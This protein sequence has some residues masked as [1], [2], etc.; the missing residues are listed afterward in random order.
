M[1]KVLKLVST[2]FPPRFIWMPSHTHGE[3]SVH[4]NTKMGST[5]LYRDEKGESDLLFG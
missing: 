2:N 4:E 5:L 1:S 3:M